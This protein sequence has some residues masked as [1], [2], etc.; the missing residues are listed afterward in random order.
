MNFVTDDLV[1]LSKVLRAVESAGDLRLLMLC[2]V[3]LEKDIAEWSLHDPRSVRQLFWPAEVTFMAEQV[4]GPIL[5]V[6]NEQDGA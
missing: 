3:L 5:W 4:D 1:E 6:N 2:L